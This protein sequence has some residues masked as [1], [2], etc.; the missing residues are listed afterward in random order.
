MSYLRYLCLSACSVSNTYCVVGFV[1][2]SCVP[3]AAT[4]SGWVIFYYSLTIYIR[5][6]DDNVR[7]VL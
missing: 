3:Y 5:S 2:S 4:F 6:H 7:F 1:S